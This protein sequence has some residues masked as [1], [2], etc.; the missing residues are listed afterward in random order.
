MD[1]YWIGAIVRWLG[2]MLTM[3]IFGS[4]GPRK[5]E[6]REEAQ[7]YRDQMHTLM[8]NHIAHLDAKQEAQTE[9]L[10]QISASM[11][12]NTMALQALHGHIRGAQ[13]KTDSAHQ[14]MSK[15]LARIEGRLDR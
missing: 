8:T 11:R 15:D 7:A 14:E 10:I 5:N 1:F 13:D 3:P 6:W 2:S 4:G 9:T 12:E